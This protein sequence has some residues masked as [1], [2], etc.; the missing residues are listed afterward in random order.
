MAN[1][2][3]TESVKLNSVLVGKVRENKKKTGV[4]IIT[5]IEKA[6]EKELKSKK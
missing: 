6:I 1:A 5:F 4:P 3:G 2:N